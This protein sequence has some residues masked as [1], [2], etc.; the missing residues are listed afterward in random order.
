M[1]RLK[2]DIPVFLLTGFLGSG[3]TTLL[4]ARAAEP[5][6]AN[7]AVVVNELGEIGLDQIGDR[8]GDRQ[9]GAARR[10]LPVLRQHRR[11]ARDARRPGRPPR[12][13]RDPALRAR[14][15]RDQRRR[16]PGA[17]AATSCSATRWSR[18]TTPSRPRSARSTRS[19]SSPR[20]PSIR[21]STSRSPSPTASSSPSATSPMPAP[22]LELSAGCR[23]TR[24][25]G[26]A[27][28][29]SRRDAR[30]TQVSCLGPDPLATGAFPGSIRAHS[31]PAR[32]A[33]DLGGLGGVV[34]ARRRE[35]FGARLHPRQR[36]AADG[37]HRR[38]RVRAGRAGRVPPAA[39]LPR[40]AGRGP[41]QPA[42]LH[43]ARHRAEETRATLPRS[44]RRPARRP[45]IH[46]GI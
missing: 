40:L 32:S 26:R 39:A 7:T 6:L 30:S 18:R 41:R 12:A 25:A 17:A 45:S 38:D 14:D 4:N 8:A 24:N 23:N 35:E 2:R 37:G 1:T 27:V 28:R 42:G 13:R 5:A 3:K 29:R 20:A 16:R 43:R 22:V 34:A 9:R 10:R 19:T 31:L 11:A 44:T 21:S 46:A 33:G 36:P 15:H